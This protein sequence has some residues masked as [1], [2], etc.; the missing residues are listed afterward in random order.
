MGVYLLV[1]FAGGKAANPDFEIYLVKDTE[2]NAIKNSTWCKSW[3]SRCHTWEYSNRGNM[4]FILNESRQVYTSKINMVR[5]T[6]KYLSRSYRKSLKSSC[7]LVVM[8][9][10]YR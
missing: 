3:I 7:S 4:D 1:E 6:W 2:V 5:K 8:A 9:V 10:R